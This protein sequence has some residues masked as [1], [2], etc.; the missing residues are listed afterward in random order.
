MSPLDALRSGWGWTGI[1]FAEI[2]AV[3]PMGHLLFTDT[4]GCFYYLDPGLLAITPLGNEAAARAHFTQEETELIWRAL[5]LVEA[6]RKRLGECPEG[7]IYSPGPLAL[8]EGRYEAEELCI[9][10]LAE[11][12]GFTGDVAR[13]IKDLPSGSKYRIKIVD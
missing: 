7:S 11:L 2:Q 9:L 5:P 12:I 13:Q 10:P 1:D 8:L 3:S 6:A 4:D